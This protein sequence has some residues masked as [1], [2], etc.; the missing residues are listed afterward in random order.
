MSE[1]ETFYLY[2]YTFSTRVQHGQ[3]KIKFFYDLL[4]TYLSQIYMKL[5]VQYTKALFF[6]FMLFFFVVVFILIF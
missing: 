2:F 5:C 4:V 3:K 1:Q 6:I